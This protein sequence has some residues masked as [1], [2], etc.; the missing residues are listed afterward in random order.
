MAITSINQLDPTRIYSYTDYLTSVFQDRLELIKGKIALMP[1]A[2]N[3]GHQQISMNLTR[4]M[5]N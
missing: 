5:V 2:P 3:S 4:P 1:P